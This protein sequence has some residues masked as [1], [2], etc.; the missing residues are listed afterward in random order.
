M[1]V[2]GAAPEA[3]SC[4]RRAGSAPVCSPQQYKDCAHPA[5]GK[6]QAS[7]TPRPHPHP[8]SAGD[9]DP[10]AGPAKREAVTRAPV[11]GRCPAAEGRVPLPQPMRQYSL[12]Q[13]ALHGADAQPRRRPLP[14]PETQ[15]QRGL[16][17]VS[18]AGPWRRGGPPPPGRT[19]VCTQGWET[20]LPNAPRLRGLWAIASTF[21]PIAGTRGVQQTLSSSRENVLVLD[22]FFEALNYE[23]VEQKK[24]YEMSELLGVS[25]PA[26]S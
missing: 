11:A 20:R 21:L 12:R 26:C 1:G 2:L 16:H 9:P 7:P 5:L 4:P 14:G 19:S 17:S 25:A 23:T 13:G 10:G 18:R 22:I 8:G 15:P 24:A 3:I 6:G